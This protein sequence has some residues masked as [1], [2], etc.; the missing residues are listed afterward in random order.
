MFSIAIFALGLVA[1][2]LALSA[3]LVPVDPPTLL[4]NGQ[5]AQALNSEF[6][7][8][9]TSDLC[10]SGQ[11]ACISKALALC[12]FSNWITET[13]PP[14]QQCFALPSVHYNG[15][16]VACTSQAEALSIISATGAT[17]G[18]YS[19]STNTNTNV[20][21]PD[22]ETLSTTTSSASVTVFTAAITI[23]LP[24]VT[25][26]ISPDAASSLLSS[27]LASA[28]GASPTTT[29]SPDAGIGI[30]PTTITV[31][32]ASVTSATGVDGAIATGSYSA[33]IAI[34]L[35]PQVATASTPTLSAD[36]GY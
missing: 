10:I 2:P 19:N 12:V 1:F 27:L 25:Q 26:T 20:S 23:T 11:R 32:S 7:N 16:F 22:P 5:D 9:T 33:P 14:S 24:P 17:G 6:Q 13:C 31:T 28:D 4:Q 35:T 30:A 34:Q 8:L 18:I 29:V 36:S 21:F 3:P 15:T